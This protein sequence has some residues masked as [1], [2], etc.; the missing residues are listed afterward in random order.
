[1]KVR[2]LMELLSE[3]DP[4]ATVRLLLQPNY[5]FEHNILGLAV[6]SDFQESLMQGE[7]DN[8]VLLLEGNQI[9]Y[10]NKDA[11]QNRR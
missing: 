10:G 11:F 6:R 8:D 1:M 5:P 7:S 4:E 3:V 9:G 2:E